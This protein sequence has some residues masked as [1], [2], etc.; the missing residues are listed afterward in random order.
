MKC[1]KL[2]AV[3]AAGF[4]L[5]LT[6]TAQAADIDAKSE[7]V[8]REMTEYAQ[9][10]KSFRAE[11]LASAKMET[12]GTSNKLKYVYSIVGEQPNRLA[13]IARS[14]EGA[15]VVVSD[16]KK[17]YAL[18]PALSKYV[19]GNAPAS[20]REIVAAESLLG[21]SLGHSIIAGACCR[22]RRTT[23][24]PGRLNRQS[25]WAKRSSAPSSATI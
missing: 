1:A 18:A 21:T 25:T 3:M 17:L 13:M 6:S 9:G 4:M 24:W 15:P 19:L 22:L 16:G 7:Q 8:L 14:G 10:L 2:A 12:G 5:V 23:N 20:L 11:M